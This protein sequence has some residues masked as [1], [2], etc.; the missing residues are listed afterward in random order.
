[1]KKITPLILLL[2][3]VLGI[4]LLVPI[5]KQ[6][7]FTPE[8][9]QTQ[10]ARKAIDCPDE[11]ITSGDLP[12]LDY[13]YSFCYPKNWQIKRWSQVDNQF[14]VQVFDPKDEVNG[15]TINGRKYN[16]EAQLPI[17]LETPFTF[18]E[19]KIHILSPSNPQVKIQNHSVYVD[20]SDMY[21]IRYEY[22][23]YS[24]TVVAIEW[25]K[26]S[27]IQDSYFEA[28]VSFNS[29]DKTESSLK[30]IGDVIVESLEMKQVGS[31]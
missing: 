26:Q 17:T 19:A 2:T 25:L 13:E 9:Q 14:Y 10:V 15:V 7:A 16:P 6:I 23:A 20:T 22:P 5:F 18:E 11:F 31:R 4:F 27:G 29:D 12:L 8:T 30:N 3:V 1:M 24:D 28:H 21:V